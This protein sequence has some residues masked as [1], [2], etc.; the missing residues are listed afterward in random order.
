MGK[1]AFAR[2]EITILDLSAC[3][4]LRTID[5][6]SFSDNKLKSVNLNGCRA[7]MKIGDDTFWGNELSEIALDHCT[8]LV[9]IGCYAFHGN[10]LNDLVLPVSNEY[11]AF[12]WKDLEGN[13]YSGGDQINDLKT[14]YYVPVAYTIR[15]EDVVVTDGIIE[16]C[17]YDFAFRSIIFPNTLDGQ[18]V[19]GIA[20]QGQENGMFRGKGIVDLVLPP[21]IEVIGEDAF[22]YNHLKNLDLGPL[23][24]LTSIGSHAFTSNAI[25]QLELGGCTSLTSIGDGAFFNHRLTNL[26]L[27]GCNALVSIGDHAF[28]CDSYN[29]L[30]GLV[31]PEHAEYSLYGWKDTNGEEYSGGSLVSDLGIGY[32][33]PVPVPYTLTDKDVVIEDG[34]IQSFSPNNGFRYIIIPETL[35][36]Q[37]VKGISH[38]KS[39]PPEVWSPRGV[40][41]HRGI[42]GVILPSTMETIGDQAFEWNYITSLDISACHALRFI[43]KD[44]FSHN[45]LDTIDFNACV[46]L[47]SIGKGAFCVNDLN[48]IRFDSCFALKNIGQEAFGGS[49][50][51]NLDFSSLKALMTIGEKAFWGYNYTIQIDLSECHSLISLGK[52]VFNGGTSKSIILPVSSDYDAYGWKDL[53]GV[54]HTG[55]A[56]VHDLETSYFIPVPYTLKDEDVEVTEGVIRE[57]SPDLPFRN[58]IIPDTLDGQAVRGITGNIFSNRGMV[59]LGLPSTLSFIEGGTFQENYL[60]H[61]DFSKCTAMTTIG[62]YAFHHNNL[63]RIDLTACTALTTLH[64]NAFVRQDDHCN[65][66]LPTPDIPEYQFHHWSDMENGKNYEGGATVTELITSYKAILSPLAKGYSVVFMLSDGSGPLPGAG[67]TLSG[68]G[69]RIT[70]IYGKAVFTDVLPKDE[71]GYTVTADGFESASSTVSVSDTDVTIHISLDQATNVSMKPEQGCL[72]YPNPARS[73]IRVEIPWEGSVRIISL[74]GNTMLI[75]KIQNGLTT[76]DTS[77]LEPGIYIL[78]AESGSKIFTRKLIIR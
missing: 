47:E 72:I 39:S 31:L 52:G 5:D 69:S 12:G 24:A 57:C 78:R 18:R 22:A 44:A 68:S 38:A 40:F 74:S 23:K 71:I 51:Q 53:N 13:H 61:V 36:G 2:N 33:I 3:K 64:D 50:A 37:T 21:T 76:I 29:G 43:G 77:G 1:R 15:D 6:G 28:R 46:A 66:L 32:Y 45:L 16:S 63:K 27:S 30:S 59:T 4:D 54:S 56:V 58:I 34:I 10:E 26:D 25:A 19:T 67:I 20:G 14:T 9:S 60:S 55:S 65:L 73:E 75:Q 41:A 7:L 17:S 62:P 49:H 42:T 70:N 48:M 8:S 11:D 35:D